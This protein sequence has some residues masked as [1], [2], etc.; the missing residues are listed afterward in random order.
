VN[1]F[2]V[3]SAFRA[4]DCKFAGVPA[5][6][7][8]R[9]SSCASTGL[10]LVKLRNRCVIKREEQIHYQRWL[11]AFSHLVGLSQAARPLAG[12]SPSVVLGRHQILQNTAELAALRQ[13]G[14][15][16]KLREPPETLARSVPQKL[17]TFATEL[18]LAVRPNPSI[19]RTSTGLAHSA[20]P[21]YVPLRGPSRW[22]PAHVKR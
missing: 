2:P 11:L 22:R 1:C 19:E 5:L 20:T 21:V 18:Q 7:R 3:K 16:N 13:T 10:Y 9:I 4:A 15:M 12:G 17:R 14:R 8:T 6:A